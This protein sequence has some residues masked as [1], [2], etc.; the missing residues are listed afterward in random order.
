MR[1][2][3]TSNLAVTINPKICTFKSICNRSSS[4]F[5]FSF[6]LD[7]VVIILLKP[8]QKP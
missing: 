8:D 5:F 7:C 1:I 6:V 2:S 3:A 4:L